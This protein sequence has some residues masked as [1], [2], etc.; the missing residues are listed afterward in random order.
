MDIS[1]MVTLESWS[2]IT[3]SLCILYACIDQKQGLLVVSVMDC[4]SVKCP[5]TYLTAY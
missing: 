1:I 4:H 2:L 5:I 3:G